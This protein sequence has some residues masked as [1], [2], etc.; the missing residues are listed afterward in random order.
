[1]TPEI[2]LCYILDYETWKREFER[3]DVTEETLL[4]GHSCGGGFLVRWLSEN[5]DI[6]VGEVVL[7]APWL[8]PENKKGGR[9]DFFVFEIDAELVSRT[10]GTTIFNSD[11]DRES[12]QESVQTIRKHIKGVEY[13]EF[14]KY[15]HFCIKDLEGEAF[16]ELLEH[17]LRQ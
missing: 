14:S 5:N 8:D 16:P 1:M 15:G 6:R 17:I 2:P 4:V 11:N 13:K 3:F 12:V 9:D 10:K 7:V